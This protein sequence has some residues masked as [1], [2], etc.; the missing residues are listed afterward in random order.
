MRLQCQE[1]ISLTEPPHTEPALPSPGRPARAAAEGCAS[2]PAHS[3][4]P[5]G[6]SVAVWPRV[7]ERT[8]PTVATATSASLRRAAASTSETG[9]VR[10]FFPLAER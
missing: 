3:L 6:R 1:Q 8:S 2:L 4:L 7:K 10:P 5:H 9:P